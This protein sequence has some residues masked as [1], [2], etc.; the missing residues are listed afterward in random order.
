[1]TDKP[2]AGEK[3]E[4]AQ[5]KKPGSPPV[6]V[7]PEGDTPEIRS[8]DQTENTSNASPYAQHLVWPFAS[9]WRLF[10]RAFLWADHH[11]GGLTALATIAI[12]VLTAF[13]VK[14]SKLQWQETK[15]A[16]DAAHDS[17]VAA[18][19][20]ADTAEESLVAV[21][22]AFLVFRGPNVEKSIDSFPSGK[23]EP[24]WQINVAWENVGTTPAASVRNLFVAS[25]VPTEP[26][27]QMFLGE[28]NTPHNAAYIGPKSVQPSQAIHR[29]DDFFPIAGAQFIGPPFPYIWGW[30]IYRDTFKNT[31]P[32]ITEFCYRLGAFGLSADKKRYLHS[33]LQC[34]N[35]NCTD[36]DC[37]DYKNLV[38]LLPANK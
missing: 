36:E 35:H 18:K 29:P 13:Y 10:R 4:E 1:L 3:R 2:E 26:D 20:A 7:A 19:S 23:I 30:V 16:A 6:A 32:H 22:R 15:K 28:A 21:Q 27:E 12:V 25:K 14:Y 31:N 24:G 34:D 8:Q 17:A 38:A 37:Q 9:I 33:W 11:S 5:V